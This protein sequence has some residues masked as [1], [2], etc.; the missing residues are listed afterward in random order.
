MKPSSELSDVELGVEF[1]TREP[2]VAAAMYHDT[3]GR[4][5]EREASLMNAN[6][7]LRD[8]LGS[9]LRY[10]GRSSVRP[11][12]DD[13]RA[14]LRLAGLEHTD[15]AELGGSAAGNRRIVNPYGTQEEYV[16]SA[17]GVL[18]MVL[19]TDAQEGTA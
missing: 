10:V 16:E 14:L 18:Q 9:A 7:I 8:A 2:R 19:T 5:R 12:T 13:E 6:R 11:D 1:F 4:L 15:L 17:F 3:T